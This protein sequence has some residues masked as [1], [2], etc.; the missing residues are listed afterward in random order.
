MVKGAV[1]KSKAWT[2]WHSDRLDRCGGQDCPYLYQ[3]VVVVR[4]TPVGKAWPLADR[5]VMGTKTRRWAGGWLLLF[6]GRA[7]K[8]ACPVHH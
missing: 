7:G 3:D 5:N 1:Y 8:Q 2:S 4:G 6:R